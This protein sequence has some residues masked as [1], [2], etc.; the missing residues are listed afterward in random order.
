[1]N[2][3]VTLVGVTFLLLC[4]RSVS[5]CNCTE[6]NNC[7]C[8]KNCTSSAAI[9]LA[10]AFLGFFIVGLVLGG[11]CMI[12]V[13]KFIKWMDGKALIFTPWPRVHSSK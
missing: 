5:A 12:V 3:V 1:M 7:T 10:V 11:G 6:C 9:G 4:I 8:P 13:V 2:S